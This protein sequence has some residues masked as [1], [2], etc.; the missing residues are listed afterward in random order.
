MIIAESISDMLEELGYEV[1]DICI[2]AKSALDKIKSNPP[3]IALFDINLKGDE[4]GIWLANQIKEDQQFPFIFLTSY[5]DKKTIDLA[6]NTSPYG[7]LIKP[8]EKQNLYGSIEVALKRFSEIINKNDDDG[9]IIRD[10]FF[11]K[12]NFQ[13]VKVNLKDITYVKSDDNYLEIYTDSN[14][15]IIRSTL[16]DFETQLPPN[17]FARVHRSYVVNR[18]RITS[19]NPIAVFIGESKI[20]LSKKYGDALLEN[21]KTLG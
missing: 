12:E 2:R 18:S 14:R 13:Y 6:V 11:V 19:F 20:P 8:I 21:F 9:F 1:A 15:H 7:Y 3:D 16:K 5:G 4:D 17:I 10:Y